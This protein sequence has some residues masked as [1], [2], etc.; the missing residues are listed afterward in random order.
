[1]TAT[2]GKR[3]V[4]RSVS[5]R[6]RPGKTA[7][8]PTVGTTAWRQAVPAHLQAPLAEA[9]RYAE[10]GDIGNALKWFGI[11]ADKCDGPGD[12]N[13][14]PVLYFGSQAAGQAY[15]AL[16]GTGQD[17]PAS[18]LAQWRFCAE[19]LIRACW[20]VHPGDAVAAH[21]YGRFLHD[22]DEWDAAIAMYRIA[23]Q[24]KPTQVESWGNLGTAYAN[25][26]DRD[27][28]SRCWMKCV[29]FEAENPSGALAQAY[30]YLRRGDYAKGWAAWEHRWTDAEFAQGYGRKTLTGKRWTGE[31]LK[32]GET[33]FV[34]GEQGL[35]DHVMFA[36]YVP[37]LQARGI[38]IVAIETRPTL[39][40]WME[41]CFPGVPVWSRSDS[42]AGRIPEHTH[43]V[44]TMSLPS[45]FG[46][47]TGTVP[48]PVAPIRWNP[49][50]RLNGNSGK[51]TQPQVDESSSD[52]AFPSAH[53]RIGG[54]VV[55]PVFLASGTRSRTTARS[56]SFAG[57]SS[58]DA[59]SAMPAYSAHGTCDSTAVP[60]DLSLDDSQSIVSCSETNSR[61]E[62]KQGRKRVALAWTG[63]TGNPADAVRSV[64]AELLD[65]LRGLDVEWVSVQF[66]PDAGMIARSWLGNDI[67]DAAETCTD[68]LDTA[69]LLTTC[70]L[71]VTVD[72]LTAHLAGSI[73]MPTI[74]LHRFD[75]EWR[76]FEPTLERSIWYASHRQWTQPAPG[77]WEP[78]LE[79]VRQELGG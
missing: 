47:L 25:T 79:R 59:S 17:V 4:G 7:V 26:G 58:E 76:W 52:D 50:V 68:V 75:R 48:D 53:P 55:S 2:S 69:N 67:E 13:L 42:D 70:D 11:C 8:V 1:M 30:V 37:L 56:S 5:G 73:G 21:N 57:L 16:R 24:L 15:F 34:H 12:P 27:A 18:Y 54:T 78:L 60:G 32:K 39:V 77:A 43:H 3:K 35:G 20:E 9:L 22:N 14:R 49:C 10:A 40:R 71:C 74:V 31:P 63:A 51:A 45:I 23:L 19:T 61:R 36:R 44:S 66:T 38:P 62:T 65:R 41:G 46:T 29:A 28:A 33:L 72:T 6:L 64:P